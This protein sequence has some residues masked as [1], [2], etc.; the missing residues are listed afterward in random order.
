MVIKL[1]GLKYSEYVVEVIIKTKNAEHFEKYR[2][3]LREL[4]KKWGVLMK[5]SVPRKVND[6][7]EQ[8]YLL[9]FIL[10]VETKLRDFIT[11]GKKFVVDGVEYQLP[12]DIDVTI[13]IEKMGEIIP[14]V[15]KYKEPKLGESAYQT[16][17]SKTGAKR[18]TVFATSKNLETLKKFADALAD[19]I[20][21][22]KGIVLHKKIYKCVGSRE[23]KAERGEYA[24]S[25]TFTAQPMKDIYITLRVPAGA[26]GFLREKAVEI[27]YKPLEYEHPEILRA[28]E[29]IPELKRLADAN[30]SLSR[31]KERHPDIY[32]KLISMSAMLADYYNDYLVWKRVH[33][34]AANIY[35]RV[36]P[37]NEETTNLYAKLY[38]DGKLVYEGKVPFSTV[39]R[40]VAITSGENAHVIEL[41]TSKYFVKVKESGEY[42]VAEI[43]CYAT[44]RVEKLLEMVRMR[45]PSKITLIPNEHK[46]LSVGGCSEISI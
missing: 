21:K 5:T 38:L 20:E 42:Y 30:V 10:G 11:S 19:D 8:R 6:T 3:L 7:Y 26:S 37:E 17:T 18:Y 22:H 44:P 23:V 9:S 36:V 4:F 43:W 29:E 24:Y 34:R 46:H 1:A 15:K 16:L 13:K 12:D 28:F 14:T 25:T 32:N 27:S 39:I 2:K 41:R 45:N 33:S 35:V 31:I 40:N